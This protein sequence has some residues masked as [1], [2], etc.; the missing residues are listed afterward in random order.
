VK[1]VW[2]RAGGGPGV[3]G[4]Q[5]LLWYGLTEVPAED[6]PHYYNAA[7]LLLHTSSSEGFPNVVQEALAGELPLVATEAGDIVDLLNGVEPS[8]GAR[9]GLRRWP[10]RSCRSSASAGGATVTS[11]FRRWD[12]CGHD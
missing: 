7:D 3:A 10:A 11:G 4:N 9:T 12:R 2:G 5:S 8:A 6:M 1:R